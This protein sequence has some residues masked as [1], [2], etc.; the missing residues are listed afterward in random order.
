MVSLL[1]DGA[2]LLSRRLADRR[3]LPERCPS[4]AVSSANV[5]QSPGPCSES[6]EVTTCRLDQRDIG[7]IAPNPFWH[8][9]SAVFFPS[10]YPFSFTTL[11]FPSLT[12][13]CGSRD[14]NTVA[15]SASHYDCNY[16]AL[17]CRA[18]SLQLRH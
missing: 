6:C 8:L 11:C 13:S 9:L 4:N 1:A 2:R 3:S 18:A 12:S 5:I 16:Q 7:R 10:A 15:A 17:K 14:T